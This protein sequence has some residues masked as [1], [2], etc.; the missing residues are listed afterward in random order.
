MGQ[1]STTHSHGL[2]NERA[3]VERWT[4]V[5]KAMTGSV[6]YLP[7]MEIVASYAGPVALYGGMVCT[8]YRPVAF[9]SMLIMLYSLM[10]P[11]FLTFSTALRLAFKPFSTTCY[12]GIALE[13]NPCSSRWRTCNTVLG[14]KPD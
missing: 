9:C 8:R 14:Q 6:S 3:C 4:A 11:Y 2:R 1:Q 7:K 13:V 5:C 12:S 10:A